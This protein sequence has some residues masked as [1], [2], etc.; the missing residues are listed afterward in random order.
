MDLPNNDEL[1]TWWISNG[2]PNR[3]VLRNG[4]IVIPNN[5]TVRYLEGLLPYFVSRRKSPKDII[6]I[7][8][9]SKDDETRVVVASDFHIPHHDVQALRVFLTFL[10]DYQPDELV[11]N[12]NINDCGGF[13]DKPKLREIGTAIKTCREER[14]I[15][16]PIAEYIRDILPNCKITYIGSQ[17]HEGWI[18]KWASLSEITRDDENYTIPKWFKL[19]EFGIDFEKEVY[20]VIGNKSLL[21]THGTV[22]RGRAGDSGRATMEME[23]TSIIQGH[24]HRLAEIYKTT[25]VSNMVAIEGGCLCERTPW[26]YLKGRRLLMDWQQGFVLLNVKGNSFSTTLVPIIRNDLDQ[27]YFWVGNDRYR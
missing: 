8:R 25:T 11:L 10:K 21:I 15:W 4:G 16:L 6:E 19:D 5:I 12:G 13:S 27:P 17:C 2:S 22:A 23:G 1:Y 20:D 3:Q 14:E 18:D 26:Y 24:T 9:E 7:N